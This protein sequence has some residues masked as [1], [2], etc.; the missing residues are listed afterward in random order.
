MYKQKRKDNNMTVY[1][2]EAVLQ[3]QGYDSDG[4]LD[5]LVY[6]VSNTGVEYEYHDEFYRM[7]FVGGYGGWTAEEILSECERH[8]IDLEEYKLEEED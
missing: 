4:L 3:E 6:Q 7:G 8:D 2:V 5:E 1:D